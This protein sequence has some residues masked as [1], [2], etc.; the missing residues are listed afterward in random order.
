MPGYKIESE[1]N[2]L[3]YERILTELYDVDRDQDET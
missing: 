3:P 2:F 1:E